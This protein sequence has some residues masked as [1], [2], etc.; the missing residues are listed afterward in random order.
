M[1]HLVYRNEIVNLW[2]TQG[3]DA[4]N[5]WDTTENDMTN[6]MTK[7]ANIR[8]TFSFAFFFTQLLLQITLFSWSRS[9][10]RH[11]INN[12]CACSASTFESETK[13]PLSR[14]LRRILQAASEKENPWELREEGGY[15]VLFLPSIP[16]SAWCD[17]GK[18]CQDG[19]HWQ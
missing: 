16:A 15:R 1:F 14:T 13:I 18:T 19:R 12:W 6:Y 5:P 8:K 17:R 3:K 7:S 4:T 9:A 11:A 2:W 10:G